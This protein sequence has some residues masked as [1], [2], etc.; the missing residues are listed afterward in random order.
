VDGASCCKSIVLE[1][2]VFT[3][4]YSRPDSVGGTTIENQDNVTRTIRSFALDRFEV[5]WGRFRQFL[6]AYDLEGRHPAQGMG[7]HPAFPDSGW[8]DA[9]SNDHALLPGSQG[10]L[11]NTLNL[12]D[13]P[14]LSADLDPSLPV[15]GVSWYVAFAFCIWD[16]GRLPTE[17][18]WTFAALGGSEGREYPWPDADRGATISHDDAQYSDDDLTS[19]G[20]APVGS[21]PSGQG[22]F[23]HDDLAGNVEEWVADAYQEK[24]DDG[25]R[26]D[27]DHA[28]DHEC[29]QRHGTNERVLHGGDFDAGAAQLRNV[30]R[31]SD[32]ASR[33]RPW[34]GLRCARDLTHD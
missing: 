17:A 7:A 2:A 11:E 3:L 8:Q 4:R 32:V 20:P 1:T 12:N 28:L 30:H 29:M 14:T 16:G 22:A 19:D 10:A 15:R 5:T 26:Q 9:W 27:G 23:G 33:A 21:H 6:W 31:S 34:F 25:C 24:L 13:Q 18:E